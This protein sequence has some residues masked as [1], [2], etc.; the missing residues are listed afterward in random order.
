MTQQKIKTDDAPIIILKRATKPIKD[1]ECVLF[2]EFPL[3]RRRRSKGRTTC[4][5]KAIRRKK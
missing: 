5:D 3:L 2:K 1:T 4:S